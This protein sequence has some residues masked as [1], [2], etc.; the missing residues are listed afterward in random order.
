MVQKLKTEKN[1]RQADD[2]IEKAIENEQKLKK[3]SIRMIIIPFSY[4]IATNQLLSTSHE[5]F[6]VEADRILGSSF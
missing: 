4:L 3:K 2:D 6:Q 5:N 1:R